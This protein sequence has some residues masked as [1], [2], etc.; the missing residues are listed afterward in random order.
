MKADNDNLTDQ[1]ESAMIAAAHERTVEVYI[2]LDK[3]TAAA[4]ELRS[5][6]KKR[7]GMIKPYEKLIQQQ[8]ES[9]EEVFN[10]SISAYADEHMKLPETPTEEF[11]NEMRQIIDSVAKQRSCPTRV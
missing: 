10:A 8:R 6:I 1:Q 9:I 11:L 3:N 4:L 5:Y 2:M 7:C